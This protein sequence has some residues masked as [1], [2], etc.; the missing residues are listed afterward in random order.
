MPAVLRGP[1]HLAKNLHRVPVLV[2][3]CLELSGTELPEKN[4]AGIWGSILPAAWSYMLAAR[5]RGLGTTWT[6]VHLARESETAAILNLPPTVRQGAL[7]PTAH[8]TGDHG[9][10]PAPREPLETVLHHDH[11]QTPTPPTP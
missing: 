7:I 11:W 9:F 2:I 6:S 10:R 1:Y 8:V 4:Q 5:T 3:P